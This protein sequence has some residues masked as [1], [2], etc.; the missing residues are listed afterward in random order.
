M[1]LAIVGTLALLA[2]APA[3]VAGASD[4]LGSPSAPCAPAKEL[5]FVC[6]A[7]HPEDLVRVPGT[8]WVIVSGFEPGGGLSLLDT[9]SLTLRRWYTGASGAGAAK[10]LGS[11]KCPGPP[12]AALLDTQG[13]SIRELGPGR[14]RLYAVNHGGRESIEIFDVSLRTGILLPTW[15]GCVL[16]PPGD[17]ANAVA[18]YANGSILATVLNR[19][20]TTKADFVRGEPT[21]GVYE[22]HPG[23]AGFHLL[24]GTELPGNN[25]LETSPDGRFFY[26]VAFGTHRIV[27]YSRHDTRRPL[28]EATSPGFMPDNIHWEGHRLVAAGMTYDEPACGGIRRIINGK[29]D[30]MLCHRGYVV[31]AV[32]PRTLRFT[33]LAYAEPNPVVN[34]IT[35]GLIVGSRLWLGSY[36]ADRVAYRE[37]PGAAPAEK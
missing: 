36:Q 17:A 18:S 28:R 34:G 25:G 9:R 20:G 26:V 13:L 6:G 29:A 10:R 33:V 24:S 8:G 31:A 32:D 11:E 35:T 30:P 3:A 2:A 5:R 16:M 7:D 15:R 23:A 1:W 22:W 21:G 37:L 14:S 27:M 19:P 4:R 12:H